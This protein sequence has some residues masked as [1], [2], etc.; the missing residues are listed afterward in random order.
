MI[1][2][3]TLLTVLLAAIVFIILFQIINLIAA[4]LGLDAVWVKIIYLIALL[5]VVIW[6][7]GLFGVTQPII[8]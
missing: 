1:T 6:A 8:R 7:F 2:F 4:K 5:I 3:T